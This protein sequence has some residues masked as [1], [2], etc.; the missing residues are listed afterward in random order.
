MVDAERETTLSI[1][2]SVEGLALEIRSLDPEE[3][4]A[5][6][7]EVIAVGDRL[8]TLSE[9]EL[10]RLATELRLSPE[11][12]PTRADL[13][14]VGRDLARVGADLA[15][16]GLGLYS[17]SA[18]LSLGSRA[19]GAEDPRA[20]DVFSW[21]GTVGTGGDSLSSLARRLL[22]LNEEQL[23]FLR[24]LLGQVRK[25]S[26]RAP[27]KNHGV[28]VKESKETVWGGIES[29]DLVRRKTRRPPTRAK[30]LNIPLVEES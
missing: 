22:A 29:E 30:R 7:R 9:A 2:A 8:R 21:G 11:P 17:A 10:A 18:H 6:A 28:V 23:Q 16:L 12:R 4:Q 27:A 25:P 3:R 5:L 24:T 14:T 1:A 13:K 19:R 15:T 20:T 26:T